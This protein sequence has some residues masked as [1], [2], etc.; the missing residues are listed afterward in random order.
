VSNVSKKEAISE[1]W[2]RGNLKW[3]CHSVQKEMYERFYS[4]EKNSV[5]CWLLSRQSGK[6]YLLAILA[7]EA[8]LQKP[9]SIIKLVTDTKVHLK[10]IF[11]PIFNEL[12]Q[13]CPADVKPSY[14]PSQFLYSFENGSQIQL[15]GSDGKHY[16]KLRGQK[17]TLVLVDEAGFCSDLDDMVTSVLLPTTT[18]T[19][20]KLVLASTPPAE[21]DHPF[22]KF[23]E[24]AEL[25]GRLV[26]K[27]V[28]DNPLLSKEQVDRLAESMGGVNSDRFKRE[29]LCAIIKEASSSAI[30]EFTADME[31]E[32][33]K[34]YQEPPFSDCY[35]AMDLGF[36]DL[37]AVVFGYYD[38]RTGKIIVQDELM[39]DFKLPNS[40]TKD[41]S[42]KILAKEE[43]LWY[44]PLTNEKKMPYLRVSDI[45]YIVLNELRINSDYQLNFQPATKEYKAAAVNNLRAFFS[46][47]RIVIHPR[48]ENLIRHLRNVKWDKNKEKFTRSPDDGHYDFVDAM[49]YLVRCVQYNKNPYP[50]SYD[51][52][53]P[54]DA[55][56]QVQSLNKYKYE[57]GNNT[58]IYRKIF[59]IKSKKGF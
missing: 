58:D 49:I 56:G 41:L 27:T 52:G 38:F 55:L 26:T 33:V 13:D 39:Y 32:I 4:A 34:E 48:C 45:D 31:K 20:G 54:Q 51:A 3:K 12:L 19:G 43:K 50:A 14:V 44:N 9:F 1:L 28:Y 16:E 21:S 59:G 35:V 23:I 5:S 24:Q 42:N 2:R 17:S 40:S 11:E 57:Y 47:R 37:T 25:N 30:P 53:P 15:A 22:L 6:S 36:K 7:L 29:Y 10:S 8:A 18:H 46:A